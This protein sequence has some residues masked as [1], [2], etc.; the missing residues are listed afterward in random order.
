LAY[1]T[2]QRKLS[3]GT[4]VVAKS[5][6]PGRLRN[7]V[8]DC[9]ALPLVWAGPRG[10]IESSSGS[11]PIDYGFRN[12]QWRAERCVEVPLAKQALDDRDPGGVLELGNVLSFAGVVG[13]TVVDKYETGPG[14][15]NVD[16]MDFNPGRRFDL[17][18]SISTLEHV[19]FDEYPQDLD[20]GQSALTHLASLADNL[21][22]T[23]P[24][25]YN[26]TFQSRFVDGPFDRVELLV[27]TSRLAKW[28]SRP[29]GEAGAVQYGAPYAYG[30]AILVGSR[31]LI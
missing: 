17:A 3:P 6:P 30:N 25:G 22:V 15:L 31:G 26:P 5:A 23:I 19:G 1:S 11:V 10:R 4:E 12:W 24:V 8:L 29:V 28:E 9:L 20:K 7:A 16:I 14:V 2:K 21:L 27:K 13:H 18:V